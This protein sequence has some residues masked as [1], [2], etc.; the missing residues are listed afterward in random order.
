MNS[1][2]PIPPPARDPHPTPTD[3]EAQ[4]L[5]APTNRIEGQGA[6]IG[7]Y[8][9]LQK[10]GEGG[11]GQVWVADQEEPV[12]RRVA[13]KVIKA[14]MDTE[15]VI[16]R[17]AAER[18]AL[19]MMDHTNIARVLDAGQTNSGRPYFVMELV[20]GVPITSYCDEL[21][22][23]LRQRLKLFIPVCQA[24]QHA[25]QKGIIHRD[26][27]PSNVLVCMQDGQPVPK[28]ID[29]G[30]AK[31]LG[32]KLTRH[33]MIT[34]F[35]AVVG[36]LEYMSPEQAELSALDIDT[37]ADVYALGVMLY[38]LLVG[39]T[40]I[41]SQQLKK[42]A[43]DEV[44]RY[45]REQEPPKPS[46]RVFDSKDTIANVAALRK[47]EPLRLTQELRG[48]LDWIVMKCLEKDRTRRYDAA[49][50]L[51][52]D[53][54]R[55]LSDEPI[56]ARPPSFVYQTHKF[57]RKNRLGIGAAAAF[58]L[59]LLG[60]TA[61]SAWQAYRATNAEKLAKANEQRAIENETL[62]RKQEQIA[63]ANEK[64]AKESAKAAEIAR[65]AE[66]Q[67]LKKQVEFAQAELSSRQQSYALVEVLEAIFDENNF[68]L[69]AVDILPRIKEKLEQIVATVDKA[70]GADP[71]LR[72]RLRQSLGGML[73]AFDDYD[74][75][76]QELQKA[77]DVHRELSGAESQSTLA[78]RNRLGLAL[79][80]ADQKEESKRVFDDVFAIR[81]RLL[82]P[83]HQDTL[84]SLHNLAWFEQKTDNPQAALVKF[85]EAYDRQK[86]LH[87]DEHLDTVDSLEALAV[88]HRE[89]GQ[90]LKSAEYCEQV[91]VRRIKL[92]GPGHWKTLRAKYNLAWAHGLVGDADKAIALY[93]ELVESR[94][95]LGGALHPR[96]IEAIS[97]LAWAYAI[98]RD[99]A[100]AIA[101]YED[102]LTKRRELL[103]YED[104]ETLETQGNLAQTYDAAGQ[105]EKAMQQFADLV[106]RL[107]LK[108]GEDA[109]ETWNS[110]S[111]YALACDHAG[112]HELAAKLY[113]EVLASKRKKLG[114][115]SPKVTVAINNLGIH[116]FNLSQY[117]K[118]LP[119]FQ[120]ALDRDLKHWGPRHHDTLVVLL[121]LGKTLNKLARYDEAI[122]KLNESLNVQLEIN[123]PAHVNTLS[124]MAALAEAHQAKGDLRSSLKLNEQIAAAWESRLGAEHEDA[125]ASWRIVRWQRSSLGDKQG[126]LDIAKKVHAL[127]A[128]TAGEQ[129]STTM[130]DL[131]YVAD[132]HETLSQPQTAE[133]MRRAYLEFIQTQPTA[134]FMTPIAKTSLARNLIQQS[135]YSDARSLLE[136]VIDYY[137]KSLP[138]NLA[139]YSVSL[140]LAKCYL[141]ESKF[142]AG[143]KLLLESVEGFKKYNSAETPT[144]MSLIAELYTRWK[145]PEEAAKWQAQANE[146]AKQAAATNTKPQGG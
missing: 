81:M 93:E 28:V 112:K 57:V 58:L 127:S 66:T 17:F 79:L 145:K 122:D 134:P 31:A 76:I 30:L 50:A 146:A 33:T 102:V 23:T 2:T 97:D 25:H 111:N 115:E 45:I 91:V 40:P 89:C 107:R 64:E 74:R 109:E 98:K 62:A 87:G 114:A 42:A 34:E 61:V 105:Y 103:G 49:A 96:T 119:A 84:V 95:K 51:A 121:N 130:M 54:E 143:E 18:Q 5:P 80:A 110:Q 72:G 3:R 124:C 135:K 68:E 144:A 52:R 10:L 123:G 13:L 14:G 139:Q 78:A 113:E 15:Q 75:A 38:E 90:S 29:F 56:E 32:Q 35:G 116:Y 44:L 120:E 73:I 48:D 43:F 41:S 137:R 27:K 140:L 69:D 70:E 128:K 83:D 138:G 60:A 126:A 63:K 88:C 133:P 53:V 117:D 125:L 36:T 46:T 65:A 99:Y 104:G 118:A 129:D 71:M 8:K 92:Q 21:H 7:P 12:K 131:T 6:M 86:K 100:K 67:S 141:E 136:E 26:I 77:V 16:A 4:T 47:T 39:S 142:D 19:A 11:M 24:I 37:R 132:M 85:Q 55:F 22:L 82:G 9:L 59:L 101:K 106:E 20:K 108:H 94:K 1:E